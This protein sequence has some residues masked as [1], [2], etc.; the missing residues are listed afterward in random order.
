M[1][2]ITLA[3]YYADGYAHS[4]RNRFEGTFKEGSKH[5]PGWYRTTDGAWFEGEWEN[6]ARCRVSERIPYPPYYESETGE[7][8]FRRPAADHLPAMDSTLSSESVDIRTSRPDSQPPKHKRKPKPPLPSPRRDSS[9]PYG[10]PTR[11]SRDGKRPGSAGQSRS[12]SPHQVTQL[13]HPHLRPSTMAL[14][15]LESVTEILSGIMQMQQQESREQRKGPVYRQKHHLSVPDASELDRSRHIH[16]SPRDRRERPSSASAAPGGWVQYASPRARL[17]AASRYGVPTRLLNLL[18]S[19]AEG[20]G[21]NPFP[22][23]AERIASIKSF[24]ATTPLL[25]TKNP[26]ATHKASNRPS[27]APHMKSRSA[28]SEQPQ[29][30]IRSQRPKSALGLGMQSPRPPQQNVHT[31]GPTVVNIGWR[32]PP[33]TNQGPGVSSGPQPPSVPLLS[34]PSASFMWEPVEYGKE[35]MNWREAAETDR[36]HPSIPMPCFP[37]ED[38]E[39]EIPHLMPFNDKMAPAWPY[40]RTYHASLNSI[41]ETFR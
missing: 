27:S 9:R 40:H 14:W 8:G 25:H 6:G 4:V 35:V 39:A 33:P 41:A 10:G 32:P 29:L 1:F 17:T 5:G 13:L 37:D 23:P 34:S 16:C 26:A 38:S 2:A 31:A 21:A 28:P 11:C 7:V 24:A 36:W 30:Q 22:V 19:E 15:L 20:L 3:Y 18:A 12:G